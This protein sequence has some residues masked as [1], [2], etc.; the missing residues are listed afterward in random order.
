MNIN[1]VSFDADCYVRLG[2][3]IKAYEKLGY[4]YMDTP[5]TV[6]P[7]ATYATY[8]GDASGYLTDDGY[9]VASG[10]Q[11]FLDLIKQGYGFK[12]CVT[13]TPCF[14]VERPN[15]THRRQFMKVEL[16]WEGEHRDEVLNDAWEVLNDLMDRPGSFDIV[17]NEKG[18][19]DIELNGIEVGSYGIR[20]FMGVTYTYGTG[21]AEPRFRVAMESA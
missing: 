1:M 8:A 4:K 15:E 18:E 2:A 10:E 3:A 21:L 7:E 11:S 16:Y 9:L 13:I 6:S 17:D 14:R 20:E 12:K 19:L 5:W